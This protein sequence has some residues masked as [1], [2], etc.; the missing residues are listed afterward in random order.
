M[1]ISNRRA[2]SCALEQLDR[3]ALPQHPIHGFSIT[4]STAT[5]CHGEPRQV[6]GG[7]GVGLGRG[8]RWR[9]RPQR[10]PGSWWWARSSP[11]HIYGAQAAGTD[12]ARTRYSRPEPT[13]A[14]TAFTRL[15]NTAKY[16]RYR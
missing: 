8:L 9:S 12:C 10:P 5:Q 4:K 13:Q 3:R 1:A 11:R 14:L 15:E 6:V 2:A 7:D 16:P